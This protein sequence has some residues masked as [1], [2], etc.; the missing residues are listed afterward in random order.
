MTAAR[1]C[2]CVSSLGVILISDF[3]SADVFWWVRH[4]HAHLF[5][6]WLKFLGCRDLEDEP[7]VLQKRKLLMH[8]E[9]KWLAMRLKEICTDEDREKLFE[10]WG[11]TQIKERKKALVLRLWDP[12]VC[13]L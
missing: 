9:R 8:R 2:A 13:H 10:R 11:I 5:S 12:S 4:L 1:W 7:T 3:V 6:E